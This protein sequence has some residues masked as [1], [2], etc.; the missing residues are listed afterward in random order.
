MPLHLPVLAAG[1][2]RTADGETV[3][4]TA[5]SLRHAARLLRGSR[6]AVTRRGGRYVHPRDGEPRRVVA[7]LPALRLEDGAA[8]LVLRARVALLPGAPG[9]LLRGLAREGV[10][11]SIFASVYRVPREGLPSEVL[12]LAEAEDGIYC[13]LVH[14]PRL[15]T[16]RGIA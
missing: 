15:R 13:D 16:E 14:G 12:G 1:I 4:W 10:G 6:V 9:S 7:T 8:G 2:A 3:E 5:A 11:L